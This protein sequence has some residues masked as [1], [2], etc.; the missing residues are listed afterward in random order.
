MQAWFISDI[1]IKSLNERNS[2]ELLRFLRFLARPQTL[3]THLFLLG[4]IFDVWI[5][6]S[7]V[8]YR[9]FKDIIDAILGLKEKGVEVIYFEGNHDL[10]MQKF[11]QR[12]GIPCWTEEKYFS[13]GKWTVR[14]EH[15]DLMN[16]NDSAYI[17]YRDF[18]RRPHMELLA[19]RVSGYFW[20]W[21]G[22]RASKKSRK[23]SGRHRVSREAELREIIRSHGERCFQEQP[24]DYIISGH[25]H[26]LDEYTF[27]NVDKKVIS[28]NLG[29][30]FEEPKILQLTESGHQWRTLADIHCD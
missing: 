14:V 11:W 1:H 28:I 6:D 29:S 13:L 18:V 7:D 4:D 9:K 2:I 24:F 20:D 16:Q 19:Y 21:L 8:F 22:A 12:F 30:W 5:G 23:H 3:S 10:H 17:R 27:K 26:I 15:G 25:M